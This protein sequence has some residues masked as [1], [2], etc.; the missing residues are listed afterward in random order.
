MGNLGVQ[1]LVLALLITLNG[2]FAL[3]E[4]SVLKAKKG[5]LQR[6]AV[7][8]ERGAKAALALLKEPGRFLSAVQV[9]MTLTGVLAGAFGGAT[10]ADPVAL[11]LE[12][13]GLPN[14][15]AHLAAFALVVGGIT[16]LTL[17]LGELVP[18]RLALRHP[19]R[20]ACAVAPPMRFL[21][22]AAAPAVW[23]L[24]ASTEGIVRLISRPG[25]DEPSVTEEEIK[26][27]LD[28]G[29]QEGILEQSERAMVKEVLRLGDRPVSLLMTHRSDIVSV[30]AGEDPDRVVETIVRTRHPEFPVCGD[31]PDDVLGVLNAKDYLTALIAGRR[32]AP[33]DQMREPLFVPST[34]SALDVLDLIK[35]RSA[36]L[37]LCV[38]EHGGVEGLVTL[39][40]FLGV[41]VGE[42]EFDQRENERP[43]L[44]R[45]DG[46]WLLSGVLGTDELRE[47]LGV[48]E[49]PGESEGR[50]KTLAGFL[51]YRLGRIPAEGDT[52][53][54][55]G[56]RFE[57]ADMDGRR[58][59]KVLASRTRPE[60]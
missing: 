12:A 50:F 32:P 8:G 59:D 30:A 55:S 53:D 18:K 23:L 56:W 4:L 43:A 40:D 60:E 22:W 36:H 25:N 47:T 10:F 34:R 2:F 33:R 11:R 5:R 1:L 35:Q 37:A 54:W 31:R 26:L 21:L 16:Y 57:V 38:D 14:P 51:L 29:V 19:N 42:G 15:Y 28:Q 41:I 44:R 49:L 7:R 9:G 24:S 39:R 20:L 17:V 6:S 48:G 46:S 27:A 58:I 13:V 52:A 45:E 3:S